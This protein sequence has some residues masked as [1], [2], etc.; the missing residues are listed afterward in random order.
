M[1]MMYDKLKANR[2]LSCVMVY[3]IKTYAITFIITT[4]H[5]T[6]GEHIKEV[7]DGCYPTV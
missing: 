1:H 6:V 5:P 2:W 3:E 7:L 4:P